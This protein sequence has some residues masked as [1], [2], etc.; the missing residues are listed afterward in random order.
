MPLVSEPS[1][2]SLVSKL[3]STLVSLAITAIGL[4]L[5]ACSESNPTSQSEIPA[6]SYSRVEKIEELTREEIVA[7]LSQFGVDNPQASI[8]FRYGA[9][10]YAIDYETQLPDGTSVTASGTLTLPVGATTR[11][12]W[13][14]YQHATSFKDDDVS[15]VKG[16]ESV[17]GIVA[18]LTASLGYLTAAPDYVG[19]GTSA[20]LD[21]PFVHQ[22]LGRHSRDFLSAAYQIAD[23]LDALSSDSLFLMGYSEGG[24]ATLALQKELATNPTKPLTL[25]ASAPMGGPYD[26]SGTMFDYMMT[27]DSLPYPSY[28]PFTLNGY[29]SLSPL[30]DNAHSLFKDEYVALIDTGFNGSQSGSELNQLLP[31]SAAQLFTDSAYQALISDKD[32]LIRSALKAND[33]IDFVPKVPTAFFHC[34]ED[35]IIPVENA[36][37]AF[38]K[39]QTAGAPVELIEKDYGS[40]V[41]CGGQILLDGIFWL[42]KY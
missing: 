9:A 1:K 11:R 31:S 6:V 13:L 18:L 26:L 10:M 23:S 5:S 7:L 32:N 19:F 14:S 35:E 33:L 34:T 27:S 21:H 12:P 17:D 41:I 36:R 40:H 30:W 25:I 38:E 8:L 28:L 24:Y 4:G 2:G 39:M 29:H 15:S 42:L 16:A 22:S 3:K 37:I 20:D